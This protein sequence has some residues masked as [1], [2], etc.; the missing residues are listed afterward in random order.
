M[1]KRLF[2][3]VLGCIFYSG[4]AFAQVYNTTQGY[5]V[6]TT[7][8][9]IRG[10]LRDRTN[11]G[12]KASIQAAG[13]SDFSEY[14]IE[15]VR[16]VFYSD[17]YYFKPVTIP[18]ESG[19]EKRFLVCLAEGPITLYKYKD[20]Y[21]VEKAG[22][23]ITK[24][25]KQD[26]REKDTLKIDTRYRRLLR[27]F[28]SDCPK[29]QNKVGKTE[30]FDRQLVDVVEAYNT[31]IDPSIRPKV[32]RKA[33]KIKIKK[34]VRAGV[35]FN[36]MNLVEGLS[37]LQSRDYDLGATTV[38]TGGIFAN[39]SYRNRLSFQPELLIIQKTGSYA[40]K[41]SGLYTF[42]YDVRQTWLQVPGSLYY[43][44]QLKK[45]QPFISVGGSVGFP[46]KNESLETNELTG[47]MDIGILNNEYGYRG[48]AGLEF[49]LTKKLHF[50][51]EYIYESATVRT[52]FTNKNIYNKTHHISTRFSF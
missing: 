45:I 38:F 33:I 49:A 1:K 16:S 10:I 5:V 50:Y 41:L 31:C 48:S 7:G 11:L 3:L 17:G 6:L 26:S 25:E 47:N 29:V 35:A 24:L 46:L 12:Q 9:T 42:T 44:F 23:P 4:I 34:G 14:P 32:Y 37:D 27:Y 21:F 28:M 13:S 15:N 51:L 40:G 22:N 52:D 18:T 43:N 2:I 8:D 39:F 20:H 30:F 19:T 36:R